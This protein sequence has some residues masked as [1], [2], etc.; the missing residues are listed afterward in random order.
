MN[1]IR[2]LAVILSLSV[3][4]SLTAC[5][6]KEDDS[7]TQEPTTVLNDIVADSVAQTVTETENIMLNTTFEYYVQDTSEHTYSE[8][9]TAPTQTVVTTTEPQDD[10]SN[11]TKERI[12]EEYKKAARKSNATAQ[13]KQSI[14]LKEINVNDGEYDNVFSVI[15][16]IIAKFLES[17][18]TET[19]GITGGFENLEAQDV[20]SAKAYK[21][22]NDTVI[23]LLMVE[24]TAGAK[25]DALSGSVG[26]A[27]TTV[28]DISQV[29]EDLAERGLPL[30]LSEEETRIYYTNPT[31]KVVINDDGEIVSGTWHYTVE[32]SM[33]NFK[34]FGK[35]VGKASVVMENIIVV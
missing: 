3:F 7:F 4:F 20:S 9:T 10:P 11:W 24:Q 26:H 13:S 34:A 31:V 28:G 5:K 1:S 22:S 35:N 8:V 19:T 14:S 15:S 17:N 27:I 6:A 33:N 2:V 16:S 23:E 12:V 18:S 32:I 25:E 30:E 21:H 29:I